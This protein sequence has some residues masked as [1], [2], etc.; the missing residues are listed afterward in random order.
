MVVHPEGR[1]AT[2]LVLAE[3]VLGN[4]L[5]AGGLDPNRQADE[6]VI[7]LPGRR[8]WP[9]RAPRRGSRCSPCPASGRPGR[10]RGPTPVA[11]VVIAV[12][13]IL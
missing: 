9:G 10:I 12:Q 3:L 2:P 8:A 5:L 13:C 11:A 7:V 4:V 6:A 1:H